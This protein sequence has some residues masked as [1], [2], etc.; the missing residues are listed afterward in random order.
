VTGFAAGGFGVFWHR[1]G[2]ARYSGMPGRGPGK[3]VM[4]TAEMT[5]IF[6][7]QSG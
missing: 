3:T 2:H 4:P 1:S 5:G 7:D 6:I